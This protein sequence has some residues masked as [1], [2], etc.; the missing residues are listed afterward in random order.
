MTHACDVEVG[1][2]ILFNGQPQVVVGHELVA[3]GTRRYVEH[4][5]T[6]FVVIEVDPTEQVQVL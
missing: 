4:L 6:S 5:T 3:C 1:D 2:R